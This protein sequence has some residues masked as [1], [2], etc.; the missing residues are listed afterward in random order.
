LLI[1]L[2]SSGA[3]CSRPDPPPAPATPDGPPPLEA[4]PRPPAGSAGARRRPAGDLGPA[5]TNGKEIYLKGTSRSGAALTATLGGSD[6]VVPA[7]VLA[8]VNCH[9]H[10]GVGKP[11][12]GIK[13]SSITW[14]E[15]TKPYDSSH[16]SG[17]QRP[18]YTR[19]R[20][21]RAITMG[22]D[23]G[24]RPLGVAM[25]RYRM[26]PA[27]LADLLA[28][29]E[30]LGIEQDPGVSEAALRIGVRLPPKQR[31]EMR[32]AVEEPLAAFFD[33]VNQ[34][35]GLYGRRIELVFDESADHTGSRTAAAPV[36][37]HDVIAY[38]APFIAGAE[39]EL[40]EAAAQ[41]RTPLIGPLTLY[42]RTGFPLNRYAFYLHSG[43][44]EQAAVLARFA[45]QRHPTGPHTAAI[46][47]SDEPNAARILPTVQ[48]AFRDRGWEVVEVAR[49]PDGA[50]GPRDLVARLSSRGVAVVLL[51]D[52]GREDQLLA[53]AD[54]AG[55]HPTVLIPAPL[56]GKRLFDAPPAFA[57]RIFLAFP[58][59]PTAPRRDSLRNRLAEKYRLPEVHHAVQVEVLSAAAVLVEGLKRT[60][61]DVSREAL[62]ERLEGLVQFDDG[63]D[64]PVSYGPNRRVGSPGSF[65][66]KVDLPG[67]ALVFLGDGTPPE[68]SPSG[69]G[70]RP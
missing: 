34:S 68:P 51:L 15:L 35:G 67:K 39:Q 54:R 38:V 11:E 29:L 19:D 59:R 69:S 20:V 25:P 21:G 4:E 53:V 32:R 55:W 57:D 66:A 31:P 17:R 30:R 49:S 2:P 24:S 27:D 28:Y 6:T 10:D 12:G 40:L 64:Q 44:D 61:R 43:I 45:S 9:G 37:R 8:C 3:G 50:G 58:V 33:V 1:L 60:G 26:S 7:A 46:L 5:E 14:A 70:R 36:I 56:A 52:G 63:L 22:L 18:A 48:Q 47:S 62:V 42:P 16:P 23:S 65:V 13:P 41:T